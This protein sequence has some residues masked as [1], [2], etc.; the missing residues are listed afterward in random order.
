MWLFLCYEVTTDMASNNQGTKEKT[1]P[2]FPVSQR[3]VDIGI[4][5]INK[6]ED[7]CRTSQQWPAHN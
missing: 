5:M 4:N 1:F 3:L 7:H 6:E 2:A